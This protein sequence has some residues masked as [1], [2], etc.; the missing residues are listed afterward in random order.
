[1]ENYSN[2]EGNDLNLF[3]YSDIDIVNFIKE[4]NEGNNNMISQESKNKNEF[5]IELAM[6]LEKKLNQNISLYQNGFKVYRQKLLADKNFLQN[7]LEDDLKKLSISQ[8]IDL[9]E[10]IKKNN[11]EKANEFFNIGQ[12]IKNNYNIKNNEKNINN[13]KFLF[14]NNYGLIQNKN[15][16]LNGNNKNLNEINCKNKLIHGLNIKE[17]YHSP[18]PNFI[19]KY[20]SKIIKENEQAN[21][22][23]NFNEDQ[24]IINNF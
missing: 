2:D 4:E 11:S 23:I 7:T 6:F 5:L 13:N 21:N 22:K 16:I 1:M 14:N 20:E 17:V 12:Y 24:K 10:N 18:S 15:T 9:L 3:K 19:N 8:L